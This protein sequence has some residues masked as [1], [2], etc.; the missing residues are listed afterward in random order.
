MLGLG[1][2]LARP[3][4]A[5]DDPPPKF[6]VGGYVKYLSSA[7]FSPSPTSP[8]TNNLIHNRVNLAWY[9]ASP[10]EVKVELR[11]RLF[12]GEEV[13]LNPNYAAQIDQYNG[14]MHLSVRWAEPKGI[15]LHTVVDRA[16][17]RYTKGKWDVTLGRQRINWGRNLTWNPNDMFNA[18]NFLDFDYEERP[19][20]DAIRVRKFWGGS[21]VAEVAFAPD[22]SIEQSV[23]AAR[24]LFNVKGYDV[25]TIT[26]YYKGD[27]ALGLGWEGNLGPIGFRGEGTWFHPLAPSADSV[28][29]TAASATLDYLTP[30]GWYLTF[31]GLYNQRGNLG[32]NPGLGLA[33]SLLSA[34]NLFPSRFAMILGASKT[35]SPVFTVSLSA[36][37]AEQNNLTGIIP[38]LTYSI[39]TNWDL[40]LVAQSF[41]ASNNGQFGE[42]ATAGFLRLKMS[43]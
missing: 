25:Q 40:D 6:T 12:I 32:N 28:D 39:K 24:V 35:I 34:K 42:A 3:A 23:G 5:Q 36:L 33:G 17:A 29:A 8:T 26:G 1:L 16:Y 19:G 10:W 37:Y 4:L 38:V 11:N 30:G 21:S 22:T 7:T 2:L 20:S 15:V 41:F 18:L 27:L 9:P 43:Y 14:L 13:K 31:A